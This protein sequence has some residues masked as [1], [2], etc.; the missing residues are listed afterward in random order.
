[1]EEINRIQNRTIIYGRGRE[2]DT[3]SSYLM[4]EENRIQNH[5]IRCWKRTGHGTIISGAGREPDTEPSHPVRKRT[6]YRTIISGPSFT[7]KPGEDTP[8]MSDRIT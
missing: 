7:L 4:Q 2:P 1:V 8:E 5:Y 6:G 3:E